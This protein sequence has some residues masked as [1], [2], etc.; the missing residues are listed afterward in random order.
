MSN[1]AWCRHFEHD[2]YVTTHDGVT[3]HHGDAW[4]A[5]FARLAGPA[6]FPAALAQSALAC[7]AAERERLRAK[8]LEL[9]PGSVLRFFEGEYP[10]E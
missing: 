2:T 8:G 5:N 7:I 4:C 10:A 1:L 9:A 6:N 3:I